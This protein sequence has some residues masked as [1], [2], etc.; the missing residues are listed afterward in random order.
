MIFLFV[1]QELYLK[2]TLWCTSFKY[3]YA[4]CIVAFIFFKHEQ[5]Q[6]HCFVVQLTFSMF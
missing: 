5:Q 2:T 1:L 3:V 4:T 6:V